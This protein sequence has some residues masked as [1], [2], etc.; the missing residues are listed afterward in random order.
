MVTFFYPNPSSV[1]KTRTLGLVTPLISIS[2]YVLKSVFSSFDVFHALI[3]DLLLS[4][5]YFILNGLIAD[6]QASP[7]RS[8]SPT[9]P[10][11]D[12]KSHASSPTA[13]CSLLLGRYYSAAHLLCLQQLIR[14]RVGMSGGVKFAIFLTYPR[15]MWQ[16][17]EANMC[18][19]VI[20]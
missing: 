3:F 18:F 8:Q 5:I 17:F 14:V 10:R 19:L 2:M 9:Q 20:S 13:Y 16:T 6:S 4:V 7:Y 1:G 15:D 12:C 11:I